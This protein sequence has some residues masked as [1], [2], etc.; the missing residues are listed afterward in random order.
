MG[1]EFG[2]SDYLRTEKD[3]RKAGYGDLRR[4]FGRRK[5]V[6]VCGDVADR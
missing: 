5:R 1:E 4:D 2:I 3:D 6:T